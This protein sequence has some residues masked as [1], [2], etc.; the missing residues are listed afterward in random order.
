MV[1]VFRFEEGYSIT[2]HPSWRCGLL[3]LILVWGVML[4]V[5]PTDLG[6]LHETTTDLLGIYQWSPNYQAAI[7]AGARV[8]NLVNLGT[9]FVLWVPGDYAQRP[10]RRVIV[11]MHGSKGNA[12]APIERE[13]EMAPKYGY[14]IVA[15]Q[16]WKGQS[17]PNEYFTSLE[18]YNLIGLALRYMQDRYGTDVHKAAYVGFSMGSARSYEV[19]YWDR[20]LGTHYFAL[21]VSHSGGV[22]LK[23]PP[24]F[25]HRLQ[26]G[27]FGPTP[28]AG[29]HFF[30]YCG[31]QDEEW[32]TEQCAQMRNAERIVRQYG[33]TIERF[34]EDPE[35]THAGYYSNPEYHEAGVQTFIRL[36]PD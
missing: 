22:P 1:R 4:P 12:Y 2:D 28:F 31:L 34:I 30:M 36:T 15:V 33:A 25:F 26:N 29:T 23:D 14:A 9:F 35:G 16:W 32:G 18:M 17:P 6:N 19:T 27:E 24:P 5:T 21:T 20:A 10:A 7:E 3:C 11:T 8:V 13:L